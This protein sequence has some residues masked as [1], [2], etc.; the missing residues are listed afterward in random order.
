M[1]VG[2]GGPEGPKRTEIRGADRYREQYEA[3]KKQVFPDGRR[4]EGDAVFFRELVV[5][6]NI[7]G[8]PYQAAGHGPLIDT[9][10]D[11]HQQMDGHEC[12]EEPVGPD[13][14]APDGPSF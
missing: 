13:V 11:D 6:L 12:N 9:Q 14:P 7:C 4:Y 10:F 1:I 2:S 8:F 5:L 3:A